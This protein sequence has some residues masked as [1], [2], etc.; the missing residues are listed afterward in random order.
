MKKVY[1][2]HPYEFKDGP[3]R[4]SCPMWMGGLPAGTCGAD[5]WGGFIPGKTF[6]D[7]YTGQEV[8]FDRKYNGYVPGLACPSHGG[9]D[10]EG[11]RAFQDGHDADGRAMWCAVWHDFENLQESPAEFHKDPWVAMARLVASSRPGAGGIA[12]KCPERRV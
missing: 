2:G 3:G 12:A 11:P 6:R 8:R 9:P 7:G 1:T 4:C 5:A 10:R